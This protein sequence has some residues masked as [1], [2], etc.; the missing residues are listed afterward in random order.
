MGYKM[1]YILVRIIGLVSIGTITLPFFGS[2]PDIYL[3]YLP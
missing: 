2:M 1:I 3:V